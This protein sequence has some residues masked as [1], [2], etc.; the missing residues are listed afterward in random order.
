MIRKL[1]LS[2]LILGCFAPLLQAKVIRSAGNGPWSSTKSW[3]GGELPATGDSVLIRAGDTIVY[4]IASDAVI[5]VVKV[6]GT[7]RFSHDVDTRLC[8]GLIKVQAGEALSEDGFNCHAPGVKEGTSGSVPLLEIGTSTAPIPAGHTAVVRLTYIEGMNPDTCPA[9]VCCGGRMELHGAPL[10]HSWVKLRSSATRGSREIELAEPVS[11]WKPGNHVLFPT[12]SMSEFYQVRNGRRVIPSEL[13]DT[14]TEEREIVAA[15]GNGLLLNE[16]LKFTHQAIGEFRG[17]VAN[18]SRNVVV[19]SADPNGVRGH[20]MYHAASAGSI[21]YAEFRHLGKKGILGCY[22]IHFHLCGDSMRGSSV[23]GVSIWDS[24]NRWLTIHGTDYL[25]VRDCVGYRSIGH[26]FFF[27]D[28]TEVN[29]ILD[30]NLAV[31]ALMGQALPKQVLTFDTNDAAGFWWAN[32]ANSFTHNVAVECEKFGYRFQMTKTPSFSPELPVRQPDGSLRMVDVRTLPFLRFEA[33]EAHSQRRFC[34]NLGGFHG[35]SETADLDRDGNVID[36]SAYL[37]GDVQG[38]GPDW[39]HPFI[40]KDF[41]AW[42][43]HWAFHTA[44]PNVQIDGFTAHDINYAFWRSNAAGNDYNHLH[45]SDPRLD[46][47]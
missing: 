16:P 5:R 28:G 1:A 25:V 14:E 7:L 8:A 21:S 18:L 40:I 17:E 43:S 29:N 24:A 41:L 9:L 23:V 15:E 12:T 6:A 30:R 31:Q 39:R 37:G 34:L 44:A 20:T 36:R 13:D 27:E 42:G 33:N 10:S 2:F 22:P 19:E 26:G 3:E 38:V 45:L 46:L 35:Q 32:C 4:D 11:G 47:L